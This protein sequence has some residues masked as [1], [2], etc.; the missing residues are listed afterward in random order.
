MLTQ[1]RLVK[2]NCGVYI[3]EP[4]GFFHTWIITKCPTC[5]VLCH[6]VTK[7]KK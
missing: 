1:K 3:T 5:I 7:W 2:N 4:Y 6:K